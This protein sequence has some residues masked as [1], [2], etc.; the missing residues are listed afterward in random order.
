MYQSK[1]DDDDDDADDY[2]LI[3]W[4]ECNIFTPMWKSMVCDKG[5]QA[6]KVALMEMGSLE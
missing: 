6:N 1:V 2:V 5:Q 3:Q 4:L